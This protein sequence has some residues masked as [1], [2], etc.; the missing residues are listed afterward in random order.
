MGSL[1]SYTAFEPLFT[2][3]LLYLLTRAPPDVRAR[4]ADALPSLPSQLRLISQPALI[5][6]LK[7]LFGLGITRRANAVLNRWALN[8]WQLSETGEK[9]DYPNEVCVIT[10]GS[11]G[12]ATE[13]IKRL[14]PLGMKIAIMDLQ[15]PPEAIQRFDNVHFYKCDITT[16]SSVDQVAA[17][18]KSE[19]GSPSILLNNA[20]IGRTYTILDVPD[21]Y[22]DKIFKINLIS[23]WYTVRVFLPD[24]IKNRKGH[25]LTTASMASYVAVPGMVDYC[26]TK[27]GAMS[28]HEGLNQE[29]KYRYDARF[30][31]TTA[32]HPYWVRTALLGDWERTIT[33]V[34]HPI[35]KPEYV[36]DEI[37]KAVLSGRSGTLVLP[38]GK[39]ILDAVTSM[40]GWPHWLH[41]ATNDMQKYVTSGLPNAKGQTGKKE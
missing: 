8:K 11:G 30:I 14:A 29:L 41:E 13:V 33:S 20:G 32:I 31:K 16:S 28:F 37:A 7:W 6:T 21:S 26:V 23:H 10:G 22:L 18:I 4:L 17:Q 40:R 34:G 25:I 38:R 24:M 3:P 15:P 2:G 9:F 12:I 1:I 19:L 39:R 36:G 5:T 27:A 35:M